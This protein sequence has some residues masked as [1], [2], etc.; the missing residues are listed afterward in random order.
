[1]KQTMS[2]QYK[3]EDFL[4][5]KNSTRSLT[6]S[7]F[8]AAVDDLAHQL[9]VYDYKFKYTDADL[10]KD[11]QQLLQ[12][13]SQSE[14]LSSTSRPGMKLCEH[15]MDNFWDIKN[16]KGKSFSNQWTFD[17]LKKVL[18]WNRKSHSTPYLSEIKR[19]IYFCSG[20]TKNTMFRPGLAKLI[21]NKYAN[22]QYVLDP[23]AGWGE[24]GRAHV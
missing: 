1:M 24:I 15:F 21:A 11:W 14:C 2:Y 18:I 3:L 23:C 7:Q 10:L 22:G 5:V 8:E 17:I 12:F 6:D 19:G 20:L 9:L 16:S 13:N 4:N